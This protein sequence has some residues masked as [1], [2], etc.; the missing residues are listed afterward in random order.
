MQNH[1]LLDRVSIVLVNTKTPANIGATAR[2][3]MNMG[4]THLVLVNP[5]HDDNGDASRLAAG[6]DHILQRA[7]VFSSLKEAVTGQ[8]LVIGTSRRKSK[9]RK[10][11][12][13][14][15]D[16]AMSVV[17][18]LD[19]NKVS[20]VF[21]NEV[22]GLEIRD[23]TLCHELISIPSAEA[24]PS[25][26]LSHAVMIVAYELFLAAVAPTAP[27]ARKLGRTED[28]ELFYDRLEDTLQAIG[29]FNGQDSIRMMHS[30]RQIFARSRL[31]SR[32]V[33]ILQGIL[34]TFNRVR[35]NSA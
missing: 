3:M 17:S 2:C 27:S 22:T 29:F 8:S 34:S 28:V 9:R 6:A 7:L 4:L 14:P 12:L 5:P 13:L 10:N 26:N 23:I 20:I 18:L 24:F 19:E 15:R 33:K 35:R 11:I 1:A 16:M 21:G 32:D 30:L 25:L 31:D